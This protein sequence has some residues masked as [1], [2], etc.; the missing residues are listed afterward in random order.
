[1]AR[2]IRP[3]FTSPFA[4]LRAQGYAGGTVR[5]RIVALLR[6]HPE[7]LTPAE[8][9]SQST[10]VVTAVL[11][12][13]GIKGLTSFSPNSGFTVGVTYQTPSVFAPVK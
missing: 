4:L 5:E 13:A 9:A 7:G 1:M 10:D 11:D 8:M 6:E 3:R 12:A 2:S